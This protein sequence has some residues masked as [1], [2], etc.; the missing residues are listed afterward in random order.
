MNILNKSLNIILKEPKYNDVYSLRKC[1]KDCLPVYYPYGYY[2]NLIDSNKHIIIVAKHEEEVIGYIIGEA[3]YEIAD[4]FHII[5]FGIL[6]KYRKNKL[7]TTLM[8][9]ITYLAQKRYFN[10]KKISL[11]VMSSNEIAIKFYEKNGFVKYKILKNYYES[12]NQDGCLYMKYLN[13]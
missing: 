9:K 1:N 4:R 7:G 11:Y 8:N 13:L 12:F 3:S 5:S 10:I 6:E 2:N